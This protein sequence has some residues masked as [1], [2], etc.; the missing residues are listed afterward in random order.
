MENQELRHPVEWT[1]DVET[2]ESEKK[3]R[4]SLGP[5]FLTLFIT[6]TILFLLVYGLK[7]TTE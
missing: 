6:L 3:S 5:M 4:F 7:K 1:N 2:W